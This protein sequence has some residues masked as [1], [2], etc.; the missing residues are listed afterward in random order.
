MPREVQSEV[1]AVGRRGRAMSTVTTR[2][3]DGCRKVITKPDHVVTVRITDWTRNHY[4]EA[5]LCQSCAT[6]FLRINGIAPLADKAPAVSLS[7]EERRP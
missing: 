3:C 4:R 5:E 6:P 2:H 7:A 1:G